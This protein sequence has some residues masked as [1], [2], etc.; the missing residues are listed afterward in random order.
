MG[1]VRLRVGLE[2]P[3]VRIG[4]STEETPIRVRVVPDTPRIRVGVVPGVAGRKGDQGDIG[5]ANSLSIGT[6]TEGPADATIT[7]AAPTQTLNL[8][9]PPGPQGDPGTPGPPG[10]GVTD[11][12]KGDI[13]VSGTGATWTIDNDVVSNAKL[14]NMAEATFKMRAAAAGTGDPIDGTAAQAKTALAL[15]KGDVGLGNVDNTSDANKPVSTATQTA[16]DAKAPLPVA[17]SWVH[18]GSASPSAV[19]AVGFTNLSAYRMLR[20]TG[21]LQPA[22]DAV[23]LYLRTDSD[24]GASYDAGASDYAWNWVRG[25]VSTTLAGEDT[26][27]ASIPVNTSGSI[28]NA[29]N[30]GITFEV[31]ITQFNSSSHAWVLVT[32]H[33]LN[34]TG[35]GVTAALGGRRLSTTAR[36][37]IQ[38]AFSSG[39]IASGLVTLEGVVG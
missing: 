1:E 31:L 13:T 22:A 38:L 14:A 33:L 35:V 20:L 12:D 24:N 6:V 4:V 2:T 15:V 18:I 10:A 39:N 30:E 7:G 26:A 8:V 21:F 19:A 3:T 32:T 27:D 16:L 23:D 36:N 11:G 34:S 37:A 17:G 5:P 25:S 29:A 28:G 9:L